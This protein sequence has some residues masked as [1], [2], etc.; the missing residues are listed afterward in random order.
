M[1]NAYLTMRISVSPEGVTTPLA[2]ENEHGRIYEVQVI[3]QKKLNYGIGEYT[4]SSEFLVYML[5]W[6]N[7]IDNNNIHAIINQIIRLEV[8]S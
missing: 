3:K 8:S 6:L 7:S 5:N 1:G 4:S 2:V